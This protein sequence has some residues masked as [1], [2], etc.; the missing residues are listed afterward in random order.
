MSDPIGNNNFKGELPLKEAYQDLLH[1]TASAVGQLA[2]IPVRVVNVLLSPLYKW[3]SQGEANIEEVSKLVAKEV[4]GLS[5]NK[6]VPPEPY[7]AVPALQALTYSLDSSE[8]RNMYAKLL[9]TAINVDLKVKAN[10]TKEEIIKQ[11]SPIDCKVL[12]KIYMSITSGIPLCSIRAQK[13]SRAPYP[14]LPSFRYL[15]DGIAFAN[16]LSILHIDSAS[17]ADISVS[18]GNLKRLGFLDK[19]KGLGY[20]ADDPYVPFETNSEIQKLRARFLDQEVDDWEVVLT[21][22]LAVLTPFGRSFSSVCI[23]APPED[24]FCQF[25]NF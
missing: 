24:S 9:A 7:V 11:L 25:V 2:S 8:L 4:E 16:D 21:K 6:L 23:G 12:H 13:K 1:P 5:E 19:G 15:D 14:S 22:D 3:I 20:V 17:I 18:I 10:P